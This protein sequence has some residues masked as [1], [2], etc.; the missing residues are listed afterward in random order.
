MINNIT[1]LGRCGTSLVM[2][3]LDVIDAPVL[4]KPPWYEPSK[5]MAENY[6]PWWMKRQKGK[7]VKLINPQQFEF[8]KRGYRILWLNRDPEQQFLS[9]CKLQKAMGRRVIGSMH[10][11]I[12][13]LKANE[14]LNLDL[15]E[16]LGDVHVMRFEDLITDPHDA[17]GRIAMHFRLQA[18]VDRMAAVV[19]QRETKVAEQMEARA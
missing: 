9:I 14:I 12:E 8:P 10:A 1:G 7:F 17:A 11:G 5:T 6:K 18:D 15:M 4:G 2:Q 3:M 13:N 16:S 19:R